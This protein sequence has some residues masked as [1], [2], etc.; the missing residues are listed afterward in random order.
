[1][2]CTKC[3]QSMPEGSKFCKRCGQPLGQTDTPPSDPGPSARTEP[4]NTQPVAPEPAYTPPVAP[5]MPPASG[6]KGKMTAV[7]IAAA[8]VAALA[9]AAVAGLLIS[10][11]FLSGGEDAPAVGAEGALRFDSVDVG[12]FPTVSVTL[13][14]D[15]P[16]A[17]SRGGVRV[18]E[19]GAERPITDFRTGAGT[20]T[21][22][23]LAEDSAAG[24]EVRH[25]TYT[26]DLLGE[27]HSGEVEYTTPYFE[28]AQVMLVSTDVSAYPKVRAYFRVEDPSG[29]AVRDLDNRAFVIR[30]SVQGGAYLAR[31]IKVVSSL[32]RQGLNIDL[33]ADKSGS[34]SWDMARTKQVMSEFVTSVDYGKGDRV[35]ILAFDDIVQQMCYYTGDR[36]LLTSGISNMSAEG[37]TALYN[38]L[39]EG[40]HNAALQGGA[41]CVIAFT[42]GGDTVGGHDPQSVITY[43]NT[44]QV[45]VYIVGVGGG[46]SDT[47]R[48]I[49][50]STGGRYWPIEDLYDLREIYGEIYAEQQ[51]LYMVEYVSDDYADPYS[52]RDLNVTVSGQGCRGQVDVG[53]AS[54]HSVANRTH[55]SRY[56]L[57]K[58]SLSWEEASRRCQEMGGHLAT[59]TSPSEE[60]QLIAMAEAQGVKY[61]WLGGYTSYDSYQNIYG[62]WVTG[63]TFS[64]QNWTPGEPSRVD[65]DGTPERYLMLWFVRGAWAWNDQRNDPAGVV[66]SMAKYMG[67][68]C[69][70][71]S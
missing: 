10:H 39:Y 31:E 45:P 28:Q 52:H 18:T 63:E 34:M 47:L 17:L 38:A 5:Y 30:E 58:E 21:F 61:L 32:D 3:G 33:V 54:A 29:N 16:A 59:I 22:S 20:A 40:I 9:M 68:V 2:F 67:F 6:N 26:V 70:Y 8:V 25:F 49:A 43:A 37:E 51:E 65:Q 23:F 4:V 57:V 19:N 69:E 64:Y 44:N 50:E 13:L 11:F 1:M 7:I 27:M 24:Q 56:E 71:E 48:H 53:F 46:R 12:S 14:C 35:E 62:H 66:S 60:R 15:D 41:R 55:T 36:G 42:D